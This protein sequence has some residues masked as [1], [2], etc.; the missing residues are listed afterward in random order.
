MIGSLGDTAMHDNVFYALSCVCMLIGSLL[1]VE[2]VKKYRISFREVGRFGWYVLTVSVVLITTFSWSDVALS[3]WGATL[4]L[5]RQASTIEGL[6]KRVRDQDTLLADYKS[7]EKA[8]KIIASDS[9]HEQSQTKIFDTLL[10]AA[11]NQAGATDKVDAAMLKQGAFATGYRVVPAYSLSQLAK[12]SDT[13]M[14]RLDADWANGG[15]VKAPDAPIA[16]PAP[17][18]PS[19]PSPAPATATPKKRCPADAIN[20]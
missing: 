20:C 8:I 5:K 18:A 6:E 15:A 17:A 7:Q 12:Y 10:T 14:E 11:K 2:V 13:P 19:Q 1:T 9:S 3:M 4:E 16:K